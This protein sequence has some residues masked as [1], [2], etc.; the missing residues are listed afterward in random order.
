MIKKYKNLVPQVD[1]D[2]FVA[3]N[4]TLVGDVTI[5]KDASIWFGCVL[6]GDMSSISVGEG[7][8]IQE[9]SVVHVDNNLSAN[10][11]KHVTIGHGAIIHACTIEDNCLIGMGAIV[12]N[13]AHIGKN[14][15]IGAGSLVTKN[16]V[17]PP[18]SMVMGLPAKMKRKLTAEEIQSIEYSAL[19]YIK[20][21]SETEE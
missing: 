4:A 19:E 10:I 21:K 8:N 14:S 1:K 11:G 17:I 20:V 9:N 5:E 15:I 6:R 7:T 18:E 12:L 2:A 16:T 13:G 3:Q